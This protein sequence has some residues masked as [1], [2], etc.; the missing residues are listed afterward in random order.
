MFSFL[1]RLVS[2]PRIHLGWRK[3]SSSKPEAQ[4]YLPPTP[5]LS[6]DDLKSSARE[7]SPVPLEQLHGARWERKMGDSELSY[8]LPS[9]EDGVNDM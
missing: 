6:S 1:Q 7:A 8:Y 3:A 4:P 9:R 2:S 5:P